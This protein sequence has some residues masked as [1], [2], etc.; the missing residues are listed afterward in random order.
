MLDY[1]LKLSYHTLHT[2]I[3]DHALFKVFLA[4]KVISLEDIKKYVDAGAS[5]MDGIVF[6]GK[7]TGVTPSNHVTQVIEHSKRVV[8]EHTK[9]LA[10]I[11]AKLEKQ[12]SAEK[13][14]S[15]SGKKGKK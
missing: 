13:A 10:L 7:D 2:K 4:L 14:Q 5:L 12:K 6:N 11:D 8:E 1:L 15:S 3:N 9:I